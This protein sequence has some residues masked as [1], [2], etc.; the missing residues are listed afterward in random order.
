MSE[1]ASIG[2][3][4]KNSSPTENK[5]ADYI[6]GHIEYSVIEHPGNQHNAV[7]IVPGFTEGRFV[8]DKFAS[9]MSRQGE[10]EVI[11]PDQPVIAAGRRAKMPVI[12]HQALALL[13][14]IEQEGLTEQPIDLIAHS[15]GSK[16]VFRLAE[17]AKAKRYTCF[18]SKKGSHSVFIS[19]A[20]SNP[21]ENLLFLGGR[22][23]RFMYRE[24]NPLPRLNLLARELD[25]T[26]EMG[27]VGWKNFRSDKKKTAREVWQL[28]KKPD[29]YKHLGSV[30]L[31]PHVLGYAKDVMFPYRVV[32]KVIEDNGENLRGYSMP[33]DNKATGASSF[34]EFKSKFEDKPGLTGRDAKRAWAHHYRNAGHNDLLFHPERTVKAILEIWDGKKILA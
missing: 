16:I 33:I 5:S 22:F 3:E 11:Y 14:I 32:K 12:D 18:D 6:N 13:K 24:G 29:I 17:L 25:P 19:P 2:A 30:G 9:T 31:E 10:R 27:R 20:G 26:G 34:R 4:N 23:S 28:S 21:K 7:L 15:F 1:S 8:F